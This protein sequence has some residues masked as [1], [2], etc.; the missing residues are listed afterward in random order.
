MKDLWPFCDNRRLLPHLVNA[1]W[2]LFL[3]GLT[4]LLPG[5][6]VA[7]TAAEPPRTEP[8][9]V[10]QSRFQRTLLSVQRADAEAR[11]DFA[12]IALSELSAALS[13]EIDLVETEIAQGAVQG[14]LRGWVLAVGQY[15]GELEQVRAAVEQGFDVRLSLGPGNQPEV[16]VDHRAIIAVHPRPGHQALLEQ[17]ILAEFCSTRDCARFTAASAIPSPEDGEPIPVSRGAVRPAWR[18]DARGPVCELRDLSVHFSASSDL[19]L[20]RALCEQFLL[21]AVRLVDE[22]AWQ[23]RHGVEVDWSGLAMSTFPTRPGQVLRL[24]DAGD[25]I[26]VS[27]PVIHGT[28]GLLARLT[29]WIRGEIGQGT[30]RPL[31]LKAADLGWEKRG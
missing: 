16:W 20:N 3:A 9:P 10:D 14:K 17:A 11:A 6:G 13:A 15:L 26:I 30:P 24:N 5:I 25:S 29:P 22:I 1:V 18:F 8:A 21:E 7:E 2:L 4:A 28:D 19:G 31:A 27:M 23:R 12:V